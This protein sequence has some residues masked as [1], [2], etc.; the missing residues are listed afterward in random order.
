MPRPLWPS[1][2]LALAVA[3][4]VAL[5]AA[6]A[7]I[8]ACSSRGEDAGRTVADGYNQPGLRLAMCGTVASFTPPSPSADGSLALAGGRW[9]VA[10]TTRVDGE[11]LL[12]GGASVCLFA[13]LDGDHRVQRAEVR[14]PP[15]DPWVTLPP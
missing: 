9:A 8:A 4:A 10:A 1:L 14:T 12:V 6:S 15:E 3:L 11:A 7:A 5:A 13:T 2:P